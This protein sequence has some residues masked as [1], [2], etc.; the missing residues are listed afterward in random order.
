MFDYGYIM[1]LAKFSGLGVLVSLSMHK[2]SASV[3]S[4]DAI[5]E[6]SQGAN[7]LSAG[8]I[9]DS[10]NTIY[11]ELDASMYRCFDK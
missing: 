8:R 9:G 4:V 3:C 2:L 10:M 11:I 7:F 5:S 6:Y 1:K